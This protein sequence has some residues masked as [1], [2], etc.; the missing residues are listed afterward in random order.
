MN[1]LK[2]ANFKLLEH[3]PLNLYMSM[4]KCSMHGTGAFLKYWQPLTLAWWRAWWTSPPTP[5]WWRAQW[6]IFTCLSTW[7]VREWE[8]CGI[9][10]KFQAQFVFSLGSW[11]ILPIDFFSVRNFQ[12]MNWSNEKYSCCQLMKMM[13]S[14]SQARWGMKDRKLARYTNWLSLSLSADESKVPISFPTFPNVIFTFT[15]WMFIIDSSL[16]WA[17]EDNSVWFNLQ[18]WPTALF[19]W[20]NLAK[21]RTFKF[22]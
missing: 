8:W 1:P 21:K 13:L 17:E 11:S 16:Q 12:S 15:A 19:K 6:M 7:F 4:T 20:Q 14:K 10:S 2:N 18:H 22:F 5:A 3:A 9:P